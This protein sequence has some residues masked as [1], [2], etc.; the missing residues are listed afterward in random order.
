MAE[1][2]RVL[3]G[4][5]A[6]GEIDPVQGGGGDLAGGLG[7]DAFLDQ[8]G[9]QGLGCLFFRWFTAGEEPLR[10]PAPPGR[11]SIRA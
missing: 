3:A 8:F 7:I 2:V 6:F 9:L 4:K 5:H 10:I 11:P 1:A